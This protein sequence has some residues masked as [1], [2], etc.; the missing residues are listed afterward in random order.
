MNRIDKIKLAIERGYT[1]NPNTGDII[2]TSGSIIKSKNS[3]GYIKLCI[4]NNGNSNTRVFGHH[5]AYYY[6]NG[7]CP[8]QID[9]IDRN[10]SNNSISNLRPLSTSENCK[11]RLGRGYYYIKSR[12]KFRVTI[13]VN[14]KSIQI[15]YFDTEEEAR[16]AYLEAKKK[17]HPEYNV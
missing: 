16:D 14:Y 3:K 1:Y 13:R 6:V 4:W 12:N 2:G 10:K 15:G 17:Y 7:N 9:H 5:F 11:N 8:E